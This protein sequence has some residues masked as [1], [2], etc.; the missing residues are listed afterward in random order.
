MY[1]IID[2]QHDHIEF[3][4]NTTSSV[5]II[6]LKN[7]S[8]NGSFTY[9]GSIPVHNSDFRP[10]LLLGKW[11]HATASPS[12][13]PTMALSQLYSTLQ[14]Q[15]QKVDLSINMNKFFEKLLH[16]STQTKTCS[17]RKIK[18]GSCYIC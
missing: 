10:T 17:C 14:R 13:A 15:R 18:I 16:Y 5:G 1:D 4:E 12:N 3:A 11:T 6:L 9:K 2:G 7:E 8:V